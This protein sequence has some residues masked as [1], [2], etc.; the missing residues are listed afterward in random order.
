MGANT[1]LCFSVSNGTICCDRSSI[2]S[3]MDVRTH[4][5]SSSSFTPQEAKMISL[6]MVMKREMR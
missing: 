5:A 2:H 6:I 4:S 1:S 3:D